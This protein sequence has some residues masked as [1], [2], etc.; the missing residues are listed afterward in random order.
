MNDGNKEVGDGGE[1]EVVVEAPPR[2]PLVVVEAE[3]GFVALEE[4]LDDKAPAAQLQTA[5][6]GRRAVEV[7]QVE[8]VRPSFALR[9]IHDQPRLRPVPGGGIKVAENVNR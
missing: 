9:P 7:G 8:V 4:L 5:L 3:I 1:D 6:G 2:T